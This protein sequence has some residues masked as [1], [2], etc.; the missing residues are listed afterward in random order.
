M[1]AEKE[2]F[3]NAVTFTDIPSTIKK[4]GYSSDNL[5]DVKTDWRNVI[6][7]LVGLVG[8]VVSMLIAMPAIH[9]MFIDQNYYSGIILSILGLFVPFFALIFTAASNFLNQWLDMI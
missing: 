8:I 7:F 3:M 5:A 2:K 6:C 1:E 9:Y 4:A